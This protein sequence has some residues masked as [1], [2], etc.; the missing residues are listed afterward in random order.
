MA[1]G[2][3]TYAGFTYLLDRFFGV[4]SRREDPRASGLLYTDVPLDD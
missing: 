4:E 1:Q 2:G 3:G